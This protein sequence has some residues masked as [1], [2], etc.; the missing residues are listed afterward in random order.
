[1]PYLRRGMGCDYA[2]DPT[3]G[4]VTTPVTG[5]IPGDQALAQIEQSGSGSAVYSGI[6]PTAVAEAALQPLGG[7]SG[8]VGWVAGGV[9]VI[10]GLLIMNM[11]KR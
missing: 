5:V 7:I 1:M 3:C 11:V 4:S 8:A 9:A 2:T 6:N 10:A